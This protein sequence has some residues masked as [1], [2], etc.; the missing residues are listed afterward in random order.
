MH[1]SHY[2]NDI[3]NCVYVLFVLQMRVMKE[4][5]KRSNELSSTQKDKVSS[6][7]DEIQRLKNRGKRL[8]QV[9]K[10]KNLLERESLTL[11]LQQANEQI[12][13]KDKKLRVKQVIT[14]HLCSMIP[15]L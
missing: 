6:L 8:E 15:C 5:L 13:H 10:Q 11:Q 12:H 2:S 9:A 3:L 7:H 4:Q 14:F 1:I